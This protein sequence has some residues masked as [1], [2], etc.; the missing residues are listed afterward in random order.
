MTTGGNTMFVNPSR[1][2]VKIQDTLCAGII[3]GTDKIRSGYGN[4]DCVYCDCTT[5]IFAVADG[6]ERFPFASR[7]ILIRLRERLATAERPADAAQWKALMNDIYADQQFLYKT[8]L[9]CVALEKTETGVIVYISHGGDSTVTIFDSSDGSI[10][11]KTR[12]DMNFAGRSKCVTDVIELRI[13]DTNLR[14]ML[15]TDGMS[16]L[17][18][19]FG[20]HIRTGDWLASHFSSSV[21][22]ICDSIHETIDEHRGNFEYDDIGFIFMDP[23]KILSQRR[24]I[25]IMGGTR[26]YEEGIFLKDGPS[27]IE[28]GWFD[29]VHIEAYLDVLA[30][31]G[32]Y[33]HSMNDC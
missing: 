17:I 22:C 15:T 4:G 30:L 10:V 5:M 23:F 8:T 25:V 9:S 31:A 29:D 33:V 27:L 32:I 11:Y 16:D 26:P 20:T 21:D 12:P 18:K 14:I 2:I 3:T 19:Q 13:D 6:T 24:S 7:D 28:D 1:R